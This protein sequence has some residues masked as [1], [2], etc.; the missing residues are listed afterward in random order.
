[1][2]TDSEIET[3]EKSGRERRKFRRKSILNRHLVTVELGD[4]RAAILID[5][6]EDGIAVQ[7]MRPLKLGT[8]MKIEFALPRGAGFIQGQGQVVWVG[9]S[10]RAGLRFVNLTQRSW[11]DLDRWLR[12]V[13][14]P[15]AEAIKNFNQRQSENGDDP[16][17]ND[18]DRLDLQTVLDLIT[19]RACTATNADGAALVVE[20]AGEF[21]CC[22]TVG[23]APDVGVMVKPQSITG[24]CMRH[25]VSIICGDIYSDLRANVAGQ[26]FAVSTVVVPIFAESR[27]IG[28]IVA[29]SGKKDA[30][31]E[32]DSGRLKRLAEIASKL[33]DELRAETAQRTTEIAV[34]PIKEKSLT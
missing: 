13:E 5:V 4:G 29:L 30:F 27:I 34:Q 18:P 11:C 25:G 21:V 32:R 10:G 20:S 23:E 8:M 22:S 9:R 6:S 12:V 16:D 19:E 3:K 1:M 17:S 2:S 24:Q 28:G 7:P 15:L 14:D 33:A 31:T 26:P